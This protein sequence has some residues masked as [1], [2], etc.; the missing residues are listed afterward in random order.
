MI[1]YIYKC[2]FSQGYKALYIAGLSPNPSIL[3]FKHILHIL[4]NSII[5]CYASDTRYISF[6]ISLSTLFHKNTFMKLILLIPQLQVTF[7]VFTVVK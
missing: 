7:N 3:V 6:I 1:K 5:I 4:K 2:L